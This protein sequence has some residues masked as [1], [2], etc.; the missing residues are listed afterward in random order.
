MDYE[1]NFGNRKKKDEKQLKEQKRYK[2]SIFKN[3]GI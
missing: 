1:M 3:E 2:R